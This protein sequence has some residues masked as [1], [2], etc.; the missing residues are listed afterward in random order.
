MKKSVILLIGLAVLNLI[1]C[2]NNQGK[3]GE[4]NS[5]IVKIGTDAGTLP[6][7][8][9]DTNRYDF[10]KIVQ[11]E[12]VAHSFKFKNTGKSNLIISSA[13]ASCGCTV[14]SYDKKP[15]APGEIGKID[16][17]FDSNNKNGIFDKKV[18]VVTNCEPNTVVLTISGE[19]IVPETKD[20]NQTKS[21][22]K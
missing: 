1:S 17:V 15:I 7:M 8:T 5:D 13:S 21:I 4:I 22:S 11:G 14:P 19:I 3:E 2:K 20:P 12:Q 16:V 18:T 6:I 9:L 10:G